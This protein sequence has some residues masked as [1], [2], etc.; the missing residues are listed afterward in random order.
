MSASGTL[1]IQSFVFQAE[2]RIF[3]SCQEI[4]DLL[5]YGWRCKLPAIDPFKSSSAKVAETCPSNKKLLVDRPGSC[6]QVRSCIAGDSFPQKRRAVRITLTHAKPCLPKHKTPHSR[7]IAVAAALAEGRTV[8]TKNTR[9]VVTIKAAKP[10]A[11]N[12]R[13]VNPA[14]AN[15]SAAPCPLPS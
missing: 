8:T 12:E 14:R 2:T 9:T 13:A 3:R 11:I 10:A 6:A 4:R 7:E 5:A 15:R 1:F